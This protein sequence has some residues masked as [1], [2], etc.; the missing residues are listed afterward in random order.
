VAPESSL[1]AGAVLHHDDRVNDD[2]RRYT[3]TTEVAHLSAEERLLAAVRELAL[4]VAREREP[5]ENPHRRD[6][7]NRPAWV[8]FVPSYARELFAPPHW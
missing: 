3:L 7:Q 1:A 5:G 4:A 8:R 6:E 2:A